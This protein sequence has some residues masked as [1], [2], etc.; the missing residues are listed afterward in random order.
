VLQPHLDA[1]GDEGGLLG[2]I[3]HLEPWH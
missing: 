1:A 2:V 3:R